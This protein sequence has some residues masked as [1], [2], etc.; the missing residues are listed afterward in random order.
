MR[1]RG[2]WCLWTCYNFCSMHV[3][4]H[5]FGI[6]PRALKLKQPSISIV[7][8]VLEFVSWVLFI[9]SCSDLQTRAEDAISYWTY[10]Y[11]KWNRNN[12]RKSVW[13]AGYRYSLRHLYTVCLPVS[14]FQMFVCSPR[15][16]LKLWLDRR[17]DHDVHLNNVQE[18]MNDCPRLY[19][20]YRHC[21]LLHVYAVASV[22]RKW[23]RAAAVVKEGRKEGVFL[24][25]SLL[26]DLNLN[27][28]S[29][30]QST[31]FW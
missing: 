22:E 18:W 21:N 10:L 30:D 12:N 31:L 1:P 8:L 25:I 2:P 4:I 20:Q 13:Y 5:G 28:E 3:Q 15:V 11:N 27:F 26:F 6:L 29:I 9:K 24:G 23:K 17:H 16:I 19:L 14:H 7:L